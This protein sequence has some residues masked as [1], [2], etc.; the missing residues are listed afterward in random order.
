[1]YVGK[2]GPRAGSTISAGNV[3]T[4]L[5]AVV[6]PPAPA[7]DGADMPAP[8]SSLPRPAAA[9]PLQALRLKAPP[10]PQPA[11]DDTDDEHQHAHHGHARRPRPTT[12]R[13]PSLVDP[14]IPVFPILPILPIFRP[15][16]CLRQAYRFLMSARTASFA[17]LS[18]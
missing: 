9:S 10:P 4:A 17:Q 15:S 3:Q 13:A 1:M 16:G 8:P 14:S 2:T 11:R 18:Q 5:T 6:V 7:V 12:H